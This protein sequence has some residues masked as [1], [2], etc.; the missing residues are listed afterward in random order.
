MADGLSLT[1]ERAHRIADSGES[2]GSL[3]LTLTSLAGVTFTYNS[4][5]THLGTLD[6]YGRWW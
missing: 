3:S 2:P 5:Q 6:R 1:G 4:A